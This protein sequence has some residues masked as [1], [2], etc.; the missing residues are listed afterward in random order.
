MMILH[1]PPKP[2]SGYPEATLRPSGSQPVGT[3]KPP[4]GYP[5]ATLRLPRS[6]PAVVEA[7]ADVNRRILRRRR[8]LAY[9]ERIASQFLC[10][11]GHRDFPCSR[12]DSGRTTG[13]RSLTE[14]VDG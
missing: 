4:S 10:E 3:R 5:E 7:A 13:E 12:S 2:P 1:A 9:S 8:A 11:P 6:Y 14:A